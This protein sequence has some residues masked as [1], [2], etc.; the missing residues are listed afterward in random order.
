MSGVWR[1]GKVGIKFKSGPALYICSS[2]KAASIEH[3]AFTSPLFHL[4]NY[5][6]PATTLLILVSELFSTFR[7]LLTSTMREIVHVQAGQCGNQIGAKFWEIG[8][9]HV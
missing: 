2:A 3:I 7:H 5:E 8:R 4:T 9:A 1:E 6:L